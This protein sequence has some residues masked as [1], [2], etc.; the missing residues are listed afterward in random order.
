MLLYTFIMNKMDYSSQ[1]HKQVLESVGQL[2]NVDLHNPGKQLPDAKLFTGF[3][4]S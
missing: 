3:R 2:F 1:P 4:N